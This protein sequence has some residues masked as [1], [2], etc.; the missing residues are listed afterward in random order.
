MR[1]VLAAAAAGSA[2][3]ASG[4]TPAAMPEDAFRH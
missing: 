1:G 3:A 4:A 2:T